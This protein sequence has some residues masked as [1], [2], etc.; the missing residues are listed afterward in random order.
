MY[1]SKND[2]F[3]AGLLAKTLEDATVRLDGFLGGQRSKSRSLCK[4]RF[5]PS[6][7][8]DQNTAKGTQFWPLGRGTMKIASGRGKL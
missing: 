3:F 6:V 4:G 2:F 1:I 7:G 8:T 5:D